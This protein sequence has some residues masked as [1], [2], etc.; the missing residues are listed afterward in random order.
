MQV[1]A[2]LDMA[3][4]VPRPKTLSRS[5]AHHHVKPPRAAAHAHES[6]PRTPTNLPEPPA[7]VR[8]GLHSDESLLLQQSSRVSQPYDERSLRQSAASQPY[9][10]RKNAIFREG[11]ASGAGSSSKQTSPL[12]GRPPVSEVSTLSMDYQED[13]A[14][15]AAITAGGT[16]IYVSPHHVPSS[17]PDRRGAR[18]LNSSQDVVSNRS[19][20]SS[21]TPDLSIGEELG[22]NPRIV[23]KE[24]SYDAEENCMLSETGIDSELGKVHY[25][26]SWT[27]A[28]I[29]IE[30]RARAGR[31]GSSPNRD[32][33]VTRPFRSNSNKRGISKPP[34]PQALLSN[35]NSSDKWGSETV[36]FSTGNK[37]RDDVLNRAKAILQSQDLQDL[38]ADDHSR[39]R[40]SPSLGEG[41]VRELGDRAL[42]DQ[43]SS[44]SADLVANYDQHHQQHAQPQNMM[45]HEL[46]EDGVAPLGGD[47]PRPQSGRHVPL[48]QIVRDVSNCRTIENGVCVR[49]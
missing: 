8:R 12:R 48:H 46:L 40:H 1:K 37:E 34:L 44:D 42:L 36:N 18:G 39:D 31:G 3:R 4:A 10:E 21:F 11:A 9:D 33:M 23:Q 38:L 45:D 43:L 15:A 32:I 30:G 24:Y 22:S 28:G 2:L 14:A 6:P 5:T 20:E 16:R 29:D 26:L 27:K 49:I 17:S 7:V 35:S 25:P 19:L 13:A 41:G 47:W